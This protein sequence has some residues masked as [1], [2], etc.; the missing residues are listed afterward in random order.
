M[1]ELTE[2]E[3]INREFWEEKKKRCHSLGCMI[4]LDDYGTGY[5]SEKLLLSISP[6]YIKVDIAIVN[7]IHN[8]PDRQAIMAYIVNY[9]HERGKYIVA[10]GVETAEEARCVISMGVDLLQGFFLAKPA[11]DP[12]DISEE[13]KKV[14]DEMRKEHYNQ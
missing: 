13:A 1:I 5:N 6:D 3:R 10:E 14:I 11:K 8:S 9:A 2:E 4:A 7:N 12:G